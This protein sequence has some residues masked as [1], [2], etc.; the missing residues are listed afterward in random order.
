[1]ARVC[2]K[3]GSKFDDR[4]AQ[5]PND[6][7]PTLI[8]GDEQ[9]LVG[10]TIDGRFTIRTLIGVGGMG[11]VYR[12]HQHSMDRDVAIKVLHKDLASNEQEVMRFFRE[13]K[14][15]SS[16]TGAHTITV[17]DFGQTDDGMLYLVME[18]LTGLSLADYMERSPEPMEP[19]RAVKII[20]QVLDAL[21][22]AHTAGVLHRDLKP[23]NIFLVEEED[24]KDFVK[25]LDFGIAKVIGRET[26][27]LTAT[28]MVVGTPTYMSPEQ[29]L[30]EELDARSDL[31]S[32]GTILFEMLAGRPP[33]EAETPVAVVVKKVHEKPPKIRQINP[34]AKVSDALENLIARIIA[35]DPGNRPNDSREIRSLLAKVMGSGFEAKDSEP[36]PSSGPAPTTASKPVEATPVSHPRTSA[37]PMEA[38]P[39]S[40]RPMATMHGATVDRA[41][42][43]TAIRPKARRVRKEKPNT[44]L[45][46]VLGGT[47]ALAIALILW[48]VLGWESETKVS[49]RDGPDQPVI[50]DGTG[51]SMADLPAAKRTTLPKQVED[52]AR[53]LWSSLSSGDVVEAVIHVEKIT[54]QRE[55]MHVGNLTPL[56]AVFLSKFMEATRETS[57]LRASRLATSALGL[58]P[59]YPD[60]Y[61]NL[62]ATSLRKGLPGFG[63]AVSA[64]VQGVKVSARYPRGVLVAAANGSFYLSQALLAM[65]LVISLIL[66]FRHGSKLVHDAGDL[67][68]AAT[69]T[70]VSLSNM[71][72]SRRSKRSFKRRIARIPIVAVLAL[73]LLFPFLAGLG[74]LS[75]VVLIMLAVSL[76][77]RR[78]EIVA[79]VLVLL[80]TFLTV[81]LGVVSHLPLKAE[82]SLGSRVWTCVREYCSKDQVSPLERAVVDKQDG[83]WTYVG[84]ALQKI[85]DAPDSSAAFSAASTYLETATP[86]KGGTVATL[87]G[88][89]KVLH[90]LAFCPE[91]VPHVGSLSSAA[92]SFENA[93]KGVREP[94][95]ALRGLAVAQGLLGRRKAMIETIDR[96]VALTRESDL[97]FQEKIPSA[98]GKQDVC[99]LLPVISSELRTPPPPDWPIYLQGLDVRNLS[100][101]LPAQKLLLG[102]LPTRGLPFFALLGLLFLPI[103]VL[104]GRR[105]RMASRCPRCGSISCSK[106]DVRSS[107]FDYCPTCLFDQV[108]PAFI[109]PLDQV[110]MQR[111]RDDIRRWDNIATPL[112]ALVVPGSVQLA[113]GRPLRGIIM[114]LGT[115]LALGWMIM[116]VA[117]L[118]DVIAYRSLERTGLSMIPPLLLFTVFLWS[119]LDVWLRR[120]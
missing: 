34:A 79:I 106:C 116:P 93:T 29:G 110:A 59:D 20:R 119:A 81:P 100:P 62:A 91:G 52:E 47:I 85:H 2:P 95:E 16:L 88:N 57:P 43:H 73:F 75:S 67:F 98:T 92:E 5:C 13:A 26:T 1:M 89:V 60:L 61:F 9:G 66:L 53:K 15:A 68:Y 58:A 12:A 18:L 24:T 3:C 49:E 45:A 63:T 39:P 64:F 19:K 72:G 17:F 103:F 107:G 10:K 90:S 118:Q 40:M 25:V 8:V 102:S 105:Y 56:A 54:Q 55:S 65:I 111:R 46:P 77:A 50:T 6:G 99:A 69:T 28:G 27:N 7:S 87:L 84:L 78:S 38:P 70:S 117:P 32:V 74:L 114:L 83:T 33:F 109:D 80:F 44:R 23:D 101:A 96:L 41:P 104:A 82:A 37:Q 22:Q 76:Y 71:T 11:A 14:A 113:K 21:V 97:T 112:F 4:V 120:K 108:R 48:A 42:L 36:P 30:G 86:D 51:T 115:A 35:T 31:Y 94:G